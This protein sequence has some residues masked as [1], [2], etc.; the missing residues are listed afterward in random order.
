MMSFLVAKELLMLSRAELFGA[1]DREKGQS[2]IS[3]L[4]LL[5]AQGA[6]YSSWIALLAESRSKLASAKR[7]SKEGMPK[8]LLML[9]K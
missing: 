7:F 1:L 8:L 3:K 5:V 2:S 6:R 4:N 9:V